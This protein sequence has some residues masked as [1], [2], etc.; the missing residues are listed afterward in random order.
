MK[1][2]RNISLLLLSSVVGIFSYSQAAVGPFGDKPDSPRSLPADNLPPFR[3][4]DAQGNLVPLPALPPGGLHHDA[5]AGP[6]STARGPTLALALEAAE[7][8]IESC[9]TKGYRIG[10]SVVDSVGEARAMIT[11]DGADGS[12]VFVAM[13]KALTALATEMPSAKAADLVANDKALLARIKPNMFVMGGALP[14]IV[15]RATIGAI[16]VSGAAGMP[17]GHQDELCAAAGLAKIQNRL[18]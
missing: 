1:P 17:F 10:V 4:L 6:E 7:T 11:A 8:A 5:G 18:K 13:R 16:G 14:I 2:N 15:N 12:H 3:M 9:R